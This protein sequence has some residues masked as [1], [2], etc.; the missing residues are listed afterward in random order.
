[1]DSMGA[2]EAETRNTKRARLS[3]PAAA[4]DSVDLISVLGDDVLLRVLAL[5]G[6]VRDAV[7][8]GALSRRWRGLWTRLPVLRF[9]SSGPPAAASR[10]GVSGNERRA[11]FERYVSFVNGVLARRARSDC[12]VETLSISYTTAATGAQDW[13]R[14][15]DGDG[16]ELEQ[17]MPA[18]AGAAAQDWIRYAFQHGV[19]SL[20]V[21]LPSAPPK[22]GRHDIVVVNPRTNKVMTLFLRGPHGYDHG[23]GDDDDTTPLVIVDDDLPSPERLETMHLALGGAR[24]R[25]PSTMRYAPLVDLSLERIEIT[26][27]GGQLLARLLSLT[28]CPRLQKLRMNKLRLPS[29]NETM[30]LDAGVLS[31]MWI[32]DVNVRSLELRAPSLRVFHIDNCCRELLRISAPRLE[33][34]TFFQLGRPP[35]RLEIDDELAHVRSLKLL[36]RAHCPSDSDETDSDSDSDENDSDSDSDETSDS[37]SDENDEKNT[38]V[39][40]LKHCSSVTCLDVTLEGEESDSECEE[41]VDMIASNVPYLPHV[42]SLTVN[43]SNEFEPHDFGVSVASLLT[44]FKNLKHLSLH[45]PLFRNMSHNERDELDLECDHPDHWTSS[46]EISMAHLQVIELIGLIGTDCEIW[47]MKSILTSARGLRKVSVSFD[48]K[49]VQHEGKM[50]AFESMLRDEGMKT[51][52]RDAFILNMNL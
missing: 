4:G 2:E 19:R 23:D 25:L 41:D 39:H 32:E 16:D 51:S 3:P 26:H 8:T 21:D 6:D 10:A 30:R 33:E 40:L 5:T 12:A 24:L 43:I 9:A 20:A 29:S 50:D 37:D 45:L 11:A 48:P 28:N 7:R 17:L 49:C 18:S 36:V 38:Y 13:I 15:Y 42:M 46:H 31:E 22:R 35:S 34:L 1:M 52:H 14:T 27:G 47:F 44:R